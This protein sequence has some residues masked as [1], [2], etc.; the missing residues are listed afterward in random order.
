MGVASLVLGIVSVIAA[1]IPLCNA[2]AF[3]PSVVGLILGIVETVKKSKTQE[4]KGMGIAG[5]I[6]NACALI[7]IIVWVV[8]IG[9][10]A[11]QVPASIPTS[12]Q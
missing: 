1:F 10:V 8:I 11:S 7:L 12:I 2:V 4:P 6:L 9:S 5:I 3:I